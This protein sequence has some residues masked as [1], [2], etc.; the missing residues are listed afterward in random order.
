[1]IRLLV[2]LGGVFLALGA[3]ARVAGGLGRPATPAE[4]YQALLKEREK[5]HEELSNARTDEERKRIQT[6]MASLPLRFLALAE[7]NP[8]DPVAV[9]ALIQ[10]VSWV[11]S[12]A[13]P[14]GGK[15]APGDRALALLVRDHVQSDRLGMAC[16]LVVF[17]FH[18]GHETFLRAV[19]EK[20][21]HP[22]V[23]ALACL[24]LA[25]FLNDRLHRLEILR[26]QDQPDLAGRYHRVFGKD[27]VEE[28][29]RQDR[30]AVARE[31]E[32][33]FA[34]AVEKDRDASIPVTYYGSGG[35]VGEKVPRP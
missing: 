15:D 35:T 34:R 12:T 20:N 13:Y 11:N 18:R 5:V 1:V 22:E 4:E 14:V 17:G 9:E 31:A 27:Y 2:T 7:A 30:A 24:S 21:P 33:L 6:R 8:G 25:Q 32:A 28:L 16:Q 3:A 10:A 23:Q 26:D 19:L 29:E